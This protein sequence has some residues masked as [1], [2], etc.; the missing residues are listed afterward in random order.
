MSNLLPMEQAHAAWIGGSILSICGTFQQMWL[1]RE[2]Y[3]ELGA[4]A[5]LKRAAH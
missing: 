2:Q 1:S 5:L 3:T 4:A